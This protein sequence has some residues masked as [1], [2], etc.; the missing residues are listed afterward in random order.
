MLTETIG[1]NV[2]GLRLVLWRHRLEYFLP[3]GPSSFDH[4]VR[5][6]TAAYICHLAA[7][8]YEA[9]GHLFTL[10]GVGPIRAAAVDLLCCRREETTVV[11]DVRTGA[12]H[13][14]TAIE[15]SHRGDR[16]TEETAL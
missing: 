10:L 1:P 11:V 3:G 5:Y 16:L 12:D 15:L 2:L 9:G 4:R 6:Y 8:M 13:R 14:S 7:S